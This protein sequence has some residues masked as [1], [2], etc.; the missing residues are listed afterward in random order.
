MSTLARVHV[1]ETAAKTGKRKK[2]KRR[3][4]GG[5]GGGVHS[6]C[7]QLL[8]CSSIWQLAV[9]CYSSYRLAVIIKLQ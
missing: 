7:K 4:E 2:R 6:N 9:T 3:E 8:A 5:G 1:H